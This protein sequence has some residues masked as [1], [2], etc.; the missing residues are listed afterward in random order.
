MQGHG[1]VKP[2]Q[3]GTV[4]RCGGPA[5]CAICALELARL[6]K[7][8]FHTEVAN[9]GWNAD[10]PQYEWQEARKKGSQDDRKIR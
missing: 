9:E 6:T 1:H 2:N 7:K 5:V 8:N 3:D 4:A 10:S